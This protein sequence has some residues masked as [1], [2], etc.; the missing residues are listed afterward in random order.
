M[1]KNLRFL[2]KEIL[3]N[4]TGKIL[5]GMQEEVLSVEKYS[6]LAVEILAVHQPVYKDWG[7][8]LEEPEQGAAVN[9][10]VVK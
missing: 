8:K 5:S 1:S 10:W 7:A 3:I 6:I 2:R 9:K 4:F